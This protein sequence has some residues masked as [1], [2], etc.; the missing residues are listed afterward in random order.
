MKT[1]L[2]KIKEQTGDFLYAVADGRNAI[3]RC[4]KISNITHIYDTTH[5]IVWILKQIY[6]KNPD[7]ISY[8]KEMAKMR[9][10]LVLSDV[11]HI[12]PPNQR[13]DSRFMILR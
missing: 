7:F 2:E 4:L 12:L 13:T 9:T 5:K 11:S 8:T 6:K 3:L 10:K 1:E